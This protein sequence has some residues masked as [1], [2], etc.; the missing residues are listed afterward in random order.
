MSN[1]CISV[2]LYRPDDESGVVD[3]WKK[4]MG[5]DSITAG[6]L[7]KRILLDPNFDDNGFLVARKQAEIV[8]AALGWNRVTDLPWGFEG[9]REQDRDTGYLIAFLINSTPESSAAGEMLLERLETFFRG[10]GK[11]HASFGDYTPSFFPAGVAPRDCPHLSGL[12]Q[13]NG[14]RAKKVNYAMGRALR[15]F[16]VPRAVQETEDELAGAGVVC[17]FFEPRR[18]L[19]VREFF[20]A[21]FP[22]WLHNFVDKIERD[23]PSDEMVIVHDRGRV[24]GYCQ[25]NYHGQTDRIGPVGIAPE[26]RGRKI[27]TVMLCRLLE[28]MRRKNLSRAWFGSTDLARTYYERLGFTVEREIYVM[29]KE[30]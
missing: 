3:F 20:G 19:A 22:T 5:P 6:I 1:G 13:K 16:Q 11:S 8:G 15:D 26:C 14:F 4:T 2:S 25:H 7:R 10:A 29:E 28:S 23:A 30:L 27:G 9:H 12:L 18:L 21:N 17:S 24:I